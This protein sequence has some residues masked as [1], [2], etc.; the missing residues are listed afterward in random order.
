[1]RWWVVHRPL[2]GHPLGQDD[3]QY[4]QITGPLAS[5]EL[6][7]NEAKKILGMGRRVRGN[8]DADNKQVMD[9]VEITKRFGAP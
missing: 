3:P 4:V 1:M 5:L 8:Y 7:E 2:P 6:A 9:E